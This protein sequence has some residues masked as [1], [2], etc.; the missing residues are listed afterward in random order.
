M[1]AIE[2]V[3]I[4]SS[5]FEDLL[6]LRTAAMRDS[7][8]RIG[9][10]D[11]ERS[12]A[13]FLASF[14]AQYTRHIVVGGCRVGFVAVTPRRDHLSLD[15]LYVQPGHQ[16]RGTGAAV[17]ARLI[18]EAR[19]QPLPLRV[20]ALRDS[21]ANRFYQ[22]HGFVLVDEDEFDLIYTLDCTTGAGTHHPGPA[23]A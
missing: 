22:R 2:L 11:P 20:C 4:D 23:A 15:H 18:A 7:L 17:L 10:F 1:L 3:A 13:R 12:R 5:D 6:A 8:V 19:Q 21:D 14:A 9:R 16:G